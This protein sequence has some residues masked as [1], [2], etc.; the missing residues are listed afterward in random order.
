MT[1]RLLPSELQT[2][3]GQA[4]PGS[5]TEYLTGMRPRDSLRL[6]R[7]MGVSGDDVELELLFRSIDHFPL[8][9]RALAG[10]VAGFRPAP[11]DLGAWRLAHPGFD[12]FTLPLVQRKSHVLAY[13]LGDL[14]AYSGEVLQTVAAF[15]A[16]VD[17][18]TIAALFVQRHKWSSQRLDSVL[19][20]LED[21]GLLGWDRRANR[22][23]LHP[24][25][26]GVVW[27]G[28][29]DVRRRAY[30]GQLEQYFSSGPAASEKIRS[31]EQ[32]LAVI[33]LMRALI[34]LARYDD[35]A[36]LYFDRLYASRH[37]FWFED[38]G[39]RYLNIAL[40]E[41]LFPAGL[42]QPPAVGPDR[43]PWSSRNW[44]TRTGM[45]AG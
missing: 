2:E 11:G 37:N 19:T 42:D 22:Y 31:A 20:D 25:V 41:G 4:W 43:I 10:E 16:P 38:I 36:D 29:D 40:L 45:S 18:Q 39:T 8:L 9:I 6:W 24:V 26:R 21:R 33:E 7:A 34:G 13:A 44:V 17:Y 3:T 32:A 23:D 5:E 14:P 30:Y 1:T 15:R 27:S 12:P 35:A 28:L